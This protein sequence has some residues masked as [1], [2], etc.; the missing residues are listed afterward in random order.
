MRPLLRQESPGT[1]ETIDSKKE[2]LQGDK[3][4][5]KSKSKRER[6]SQKEN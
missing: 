1:V 3:N 6:N 2:T 4:K 5:N